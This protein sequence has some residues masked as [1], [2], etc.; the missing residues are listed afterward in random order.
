MKKFSLV[1]FVGLILLSFLLVGCVST[2]GKDITDMSSTEVLVWMG[3]VYNFQFDD[4]KKLTGYTKNTKGEWEKTSVP[5]LS[6]DKRKYL[7]EK[8]DL[9]IKVK[10]MIDAY[11]ALVDINI[12]PG[13][14]MQAQIV[15]ILLALINLYE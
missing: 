15:E 14:D 5:N 6:E 13:T 12:D 1:A 4:H 11:K 2:G 10:P 8:R 7:N 3:G 9:L